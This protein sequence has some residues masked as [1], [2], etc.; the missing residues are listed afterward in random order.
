MDSSYEIDQVALSVAIRERDH[1]IFRF[2]TI[3][4]RLF[5]D[6]R[7]TVA[8]GP[9]VFVL[10]PANSVR[11]RMTSIRE[12]RPALPRPEQLNVIA[13]PLRVGSLERIGILDDVRHR[14]ALL[15]APEALEALEDAMAQLQTSEAAEVQRAISGEGYR[16][17]WTASA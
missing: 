15:E 13:W 1:L 6:F 7:Y 8:V 10:P 9:G 3:A 14:L 11:E 16:T 2:T 5:I 4:L 17:I 12:V